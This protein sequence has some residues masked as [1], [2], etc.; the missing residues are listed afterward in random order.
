MASSVYARDGWRTNH[1]LILTFALALPASKDREGICPL[2][3]ST[4]SKEHSALGAIKVCRL[5]GEVGVC[6]TVYPAE[7]L[8]VAFWSRDMTCRK[9]FQW[10]LFNSHQKSRCERKHITNVALNN[11][12]INNT[13]TCVERE[14]EMPKRS[15]FF[16][17]S[18]RGFGTQ[19]AL[20]QKMKNDLSEPRTSNII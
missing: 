5:C 11:F 7:L 17:D 2:P 4:T 19:T 8:A 12:L 9:V 6:I 3:S 10:L 13:H 15:W 18:N 20:S 1:A 14:R 16:Y